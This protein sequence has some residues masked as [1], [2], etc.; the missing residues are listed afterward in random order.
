MNR[1]ELPLSL[2]QLKYVD[3]WITS[4]MKKSW[5][6]LF[7]I[8]DFVFRFARYN[9]RPIDYSLRK[10]PRTRGTVTETHYRLQLLSSS[11][12]NQERGLTVTFSQFFAAFITFSTLSSSVR[13]TVQWESRNWRSSSSA[14]TN[15]DV[16][17]E[18]WLC[19]WLS[20][21][22]IFEKQ[23]ISYIQWT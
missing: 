6:I 16:D 10:T 4:L 14:T 11:I 23:W 17:F 18:V 20:L 7:T 21:S 1:V 5:K 13:T 8:G 9:R 3:I 2:D 12:C 22:M 19:L 15:Y